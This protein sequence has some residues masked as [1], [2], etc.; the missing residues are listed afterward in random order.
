VEDA[1]HDRK[2]EGGGERRRVSRSSHKLVG[3]IIH[4]VP[5]LIINLWVNYCLQLPPAR[6]AAKLLISIRSPEIA[7]RL[8]HLAIR[9]LPTPGV[10][11]RIRSTLRQEQKMSIEK[12]SLISKNAAKKAAKKAVQ[13]KPEV[14]TPGMT[15]VSHLKVG[16][17][18]ISLN[19]IGLNRISPTRVR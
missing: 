18:R 14:S 3:L 13:A 6:S 15:K 19:R 4:L 8:F 10:A 16:V 1:C 7:S 9:L 17:N 11:A 12:K 5:W 2:I